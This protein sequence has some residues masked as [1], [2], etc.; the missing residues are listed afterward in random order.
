MISVD[1]TVCGVFSAREKISRVFENERGRNVWII[2][3]GTGHRLSGMHAKY[4]ASI[5]ATEV[6]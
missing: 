2:S 3:N 6:N 1:C 5:K 4:P